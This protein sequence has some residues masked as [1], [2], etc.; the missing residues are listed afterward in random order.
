M[1]KLQNY[2]ENELPR[3]KKHHF[4]LG[5]LINE[6]LALIGFV[7]DLIF[8]LP[9]IAFNTFLILAIGFHLWKE[10]V[11]DW[12]EGKGNPEFWDF[13]CG[14]RNAFLL[15]FVGNICFFVL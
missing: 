6:P 10:V 5:D 15:L 11:H 4:I 3:D 14:S 13:F 8:G 12:R 7:I 2:I 9:L 1:S